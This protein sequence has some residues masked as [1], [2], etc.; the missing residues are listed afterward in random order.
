M[1]IWCKNYKRLSSI[2]EAWIYGAGRTRECQHSRYGYT[3]LERYKVV[4]SEDL[5]AL[6]LLDGFFENKEPWKLQA[7]TYISPYLLTL[8]W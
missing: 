6:E 5:R 7:V 4:S 2:F 3:V 8:V 1:N